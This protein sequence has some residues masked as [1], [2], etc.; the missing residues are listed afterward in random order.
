MEKSHTNHYD[1]D[2]IIYIYDKSKKKNQ[3]SMKYN[4]PEI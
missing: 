1:T 3:I 4:K 2:N